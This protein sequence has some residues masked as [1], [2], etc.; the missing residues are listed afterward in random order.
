MNTF[1]TLN[2]GN[3]PASQTSIPIPGMVYPNADGYTFE[4]L[5]NG[6]FSVQVIVSVLGAQIA[7]PNNFPDDAT[8]MVRIKIPTANR[9]LTNTYINDSAGHIWFQF[10]NIP[11]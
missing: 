2:L 11:V 8:V 7:I 4:A 9:T 6:V 3:F 1:S 10:T 5:V